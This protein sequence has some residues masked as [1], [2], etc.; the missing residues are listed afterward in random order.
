MNI[1]VLEAHG[2][3]PGDLSW[4]ALSELGSLTLYP[5]TAPDEVVARAKDAEI[6]LI[7]KVVMDAQTIAQL[8]RLRYIGVQATGYNVVDC[9]AARQRGI[10]VT[11]IPAYSTDSV[12]QLV[13]AHILNALNHVADYAAETRAGKWA[14]SPDFCYWNAPIHELAGL[15]I[16]IVGLGHIG[17]RVAHIADAFGMHIYACTSKHAASLPPH[18]MK[19]EM[20]GLLAASDI[21]T[22]HCPLTPDTRHLI[23]ADSL[24]R[25]RPGAILV[26]TGRG[27]LVDEEAVADALQT[28]RLAA[29]CADVMAQ[30]PPAADNRLMREPHAYI[31]PHLAWGTVEARTRLMKIAADNVRAFLDGKPVNVVD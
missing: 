14:A 7:N 16:G 17:Q 19:A 23:C 20:D 8:P 12:A 2:V 29:Y 27:P 4:Q 6:V 10:I 13:F 22:L 31:T 9:A 21:V 1:V 26:N 25:M 3:N 5:R 11:N 28:G 30:E 24:S 15:S 18:V